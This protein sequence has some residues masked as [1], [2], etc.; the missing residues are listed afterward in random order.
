[1]DAPLI[2]YVK[3]FALFLENSIIKRLREGRFNMGQIRSL[4][5]FD[6]KIHQK[7]V[8][9]TIIQKDVD[10]KLML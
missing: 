7:I 3:T 9:N 6:K 2:R 1:M 8:K 10:R 5:R 4:F